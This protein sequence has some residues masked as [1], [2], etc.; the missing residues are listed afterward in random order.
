MVR[1]GGSLKP[2][3]GQDEVYDAVFLA[4]HSAERLVT[5]PRTAARTLCGRHLDWIEL[6]R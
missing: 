2:G 5:L 4:P 6:V 1:G 3:N